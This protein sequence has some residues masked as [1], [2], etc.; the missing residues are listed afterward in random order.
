MSLSLR[1]G[2][3]SALAGLTGLALSIA[4][5]LAASPAFAAPDGTPSNPYSPAAGHS[6]RHGVTPTVE[7]QQKMNTWAQQHASQ[8][9]TAAT[10]QQTLAYG[11]GVDGIGVTSGTPKVYLVFWGTQWGTQG[12]DSSGNLTFSSDTAG[13]APRLQNLFKGLGT[14]GEGWSGVMTQYCDGPLVTTGST[15]CPSGAPHVGYPTG[16]N[17][18]GVWYDN[19]ASEPSAATGAQLGTEAVKAAGHFGN[20][21]ASSN[22]YT[23]Y[24]ILSAKGL[25]PDNYK[26]G[27]FCAWHDWNGDVG[28]SSSYGDIAFT[29]M[30]Y[31]MDQGTSCGQNFVN[32]G[33]A[34][35]LDG[36]TM[37]EG[38]E[39]AETISD[40]NPAGGW[41]NQVTGS[42][43]NGQENAD[44]CAWISSGQ[45][46][47]A[48][49]SM[50]N[51]SYAMQ[52]TWSNDTNRCDIT[53][54][55]VGGSTG[56]TVTVT[57]PGN[58]TG[59]VGT[60]TSLQITATDSASGQTLT[61]SASGLPA[62]LSIN[63]STGLIS[64]TPTTAATYSTVVTATDTT[65]AKGTASFS[66][67]ISSTSGGCSGQKLG[68]PG[69]ESGNTVWSASSGVIGQNGASE[70]T[71]SGT[72]DA[73]LDGYGS[74]H[75]DTVSQSVTIPSGCHATLSFYVHIDTAET[76]TTTAYD[77]LT[78]K[79][80]STTLSTLSNLNAG[81][82]YVLKSYDV[83]S[84]AG[85]TVSISFT[86][87][88]DSSLQTSFVL[89]DTAVNLS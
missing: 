64:G 63:S 33:S 1:S 56:N 47:S 39:Y 61:Y 87:T 10:G 26:T 30:P 68:N 62:G 18:A 25:N 46:A 82:G 60:A 77:T 3:T 57:N 81:S 83:S 6:Y 76:T 71:H 35:T 11:G 24:V 49:V 9:A 28:V 8:N 14:G 89:D 69:F 73:W 75:T 36:Y 45:G 22:R 21:S 7:Q 55:T 85:Q 52:S 51:G 19:S 12:T 29:N 34:G 2:R 66:W 15:T 41:T 65:G 50:G 5:G 16:G 88:E 67:T 23:Q 17:L 84:F 78:V 48:N 86:G 40:Q 42:S 44:E 20:T 43:Y 32:S 13:G 74:S 31:V 79:A 72:W 80:G 70:P 54:A 53:H 4:A 37:V 59:T 27:G 38:H 58:Q